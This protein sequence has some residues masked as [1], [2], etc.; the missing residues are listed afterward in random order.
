[1][2]S[3]RRSKPAGAEV[4]IDGGFVR[5]TDIVK[6]LCLGARAVG[7]ARLQAWALAAGGHPAVAQM[8]LNL[9]EEVKNAMGLIGATSV[10]GLGKEYL[11]RVTP[12]GPT[13]EHSAFRHLGDAWAECTD[14]GKRPAP[15]PD[16]SAPCRFRRC[17]RESADLGGS[18]LRR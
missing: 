14:P 9:E 16:S 5:G 12:M 10:A 8:L 18:A 6:A 17:H 7:I 4:W 2:A 11:T 15:H 13:H 1:M 3:R